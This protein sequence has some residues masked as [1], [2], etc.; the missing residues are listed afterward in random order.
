MHRLRQRLRPVESDLLLHRKREHH[1]VAQSLRL[2][3]A[4][5]QEER[6]AAGAVVHRPPRAERSVQAPERLRDRDGIARGDAERL[7]RLPRGD[8]KLHPDGVPGE[9]GRSLRGGRLEIVRPRRHDAADVPLRR[10]DQHHLPLV[11][12]LEESAGRPDFERAVVAD[13]LYEITGLVHVRDEQ[14][15]PGAVFRAGRDQQVAFGVD[16]GLRPGWQ[17]R[18]DPIAHRLLAGGDPGCV[19]EGLQDREAHALA[20]RLPAETLFDT[21]FR[22]TGSTPNI[23]GAKPG[24]RASQLADAATDVG[25]GLLRGRHRGRDV[26]GSLLRRGDRGGDVSSVTNG[27]ERGCC[28]P[29]LPH[30]VVDLCVRRGLRGTVALGKG[31]LGDEL[32]GET[33]RFRAE[34]VAPAFDLAGSVVASFNRAHLRYIAGLV[35]LK[36][37]FKAEAVIKR[38]CRLQVELSRKAGHRD[39]GPYPSFQVRQGGEPRDDAFLL[40]RL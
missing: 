10:V 32:V 16:V 2:Q 20:R 24:Q 13:R 5:R 14:Q 27:S 4:Q 29:S 17:K 40:Q 7:G 21:V 38:G 30:R 36:S 9:R 25:S 6:G 1:P 34:T 15:G 11:E 18:P 26:G 12:R 35:R 31:L 3:P 19:D 33:P 39:G 22:V 23:P 28:F 8:A 37:S